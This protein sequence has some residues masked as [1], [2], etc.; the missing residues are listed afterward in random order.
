MNNIQR[1]AKIENKNDKKNRGCTKNEHPLYI[2]FYLF[3]SCFLDVV[4]EPLHQLAT[5][6]FRVELQV[7]FLDLRG[8]L[9]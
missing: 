2:D 6:R 8:S 4:Y 5:F 1:K 9:V 3:I 7:L